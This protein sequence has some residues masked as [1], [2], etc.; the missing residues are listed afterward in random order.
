MSSLLVVL[1]LKALVVLYR[2]SSH[3]NWAFK[4]WLILDPF[5][6]LMHWFSEHRLNH[7]SRNKARLPSKNSSG[8]IIVVYFRPEI[9]P[10]LRDNLTFSLTLLLVLLNLLILTN[11]IHEL[12]YTGNRFPRQRLP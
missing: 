3:L 1:A 4:V 8:L 7:L 10:I 9:P 11:L 5:Q 2:V 6:D 12:A